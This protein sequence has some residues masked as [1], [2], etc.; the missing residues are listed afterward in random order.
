MNIVGQK[1]LSAILLALKHDEVKITEGLE[2][3]NEFEQYQKE[4]S[5][6][7]ESHGSSLG[8]ILTSIESFKNLE[9]DLKTGLG[10]LPLEELP[11]I[12]DALGIMSFDAEDDPEIAATE[13]TDEAKLAEDDIMSCIVILQAFDL[14]SQTLKNRSNEL[15][16]IMNLLNS[17]KSQEIEW[18]VLRDK[19]IEMFLEK[20][21]TGP[22]KSTFNF[23]LGYL[24]AVKNQ[25]EETPVQEDLFF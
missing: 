25:T 9:E 1:I 5:A 13:I 22:E 21:S 17:Y 20:F 12:L 8:D 6:I 11:D 15:S 3:L 10:N 4:C 19:I 23:Y 18:T 7:L 16:E 24:E 2:L 14:V